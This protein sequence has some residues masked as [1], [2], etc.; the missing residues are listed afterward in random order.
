MVRVSGIPFMAGGGMAAQ[1]GSE[2]GSIYRNI[3]KE[4]RSPVIREWKVMSAAGYRKAVGAMPEGLEPGPADLFM[5]VRLQGEQL[6]LLL[7]EHAATGEYKAV[8]IFR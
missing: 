4:T 7:R 6:T 3:L 5:V 8:G 2:V 1:S